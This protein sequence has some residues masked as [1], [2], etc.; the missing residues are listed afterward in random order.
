[1]LI[2]VLE[3]S[4]FDVDIDFKKVIIEADNV[5]DYLVPYKLLYLHL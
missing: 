1:M 5:M 3:K 2:P 4:G